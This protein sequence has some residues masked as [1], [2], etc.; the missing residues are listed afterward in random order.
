MSR[1]INTIKLLCRAVLNS[2]YVDGMF[3]VVGEADDR[4]R[5][6]HDTL[7]QAIQAQ[8]PGCD[9]ALDSSTDPA[10]SPSIRCTSKPG[11]FLLRHV[12]CQ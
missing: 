12:A 6:L 5:G 1:T 10:R 7:L 4:G 3:P 2:A 8:Q 11:E 9:D